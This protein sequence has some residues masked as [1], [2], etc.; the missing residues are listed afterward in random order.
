MRNLLLAVWIA[1]PLGAAAATPISVTLEVQNMTCELCPITVRKSL[2]KVPGVSAVTVDREHK[3]A[4]VT[5]DP[6]QT[7][8]QALTAA[9]A[10]AGYHSTVER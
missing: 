2:E 8:T 3:T 1:L 10:N 5:Y 6:D 4:T 7:G 9:T